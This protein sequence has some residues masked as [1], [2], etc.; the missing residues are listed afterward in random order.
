MALGCAHEVALSVH[1]VARK[2]PIV[3][4][5]ALLA[6]SEPRPAHTLLRAPGVGAHCGGDGRHEHRG[7]TDEAPAPHELASEGRVGER[8]G[9]AREDGEH[10]IGKVATEEVVVRGLAREVSRGQARRVP[11]SL[12]TA[13]TIAVSIGTSSTNSDYTG[14]AILA[15]NGTWW[16]D[17]VV[18]TYVTA[19][20]LQVKVTDASTN[21]YIYPWKSMYVKESM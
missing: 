11:V 17:I 13:A 16:C 19:P 2:K 3:E 10:G 20:Y 9:L 7:L 12:R 18:P 4:S 8:A 1:R 14:S 15:T 6:V 21:S 5:Q